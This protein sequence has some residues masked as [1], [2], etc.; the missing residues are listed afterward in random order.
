MQKIGKKWDSWIIAALI[1]IIESRG[2]ESENWARTAV[3]AIIEGAQWDLEVGR[4]LESVFSQWRE[5]STAPLTNAKA[6]EKW[7]PSCKLV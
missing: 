2:D 4:N 3:N 6:L 5:K 1:D 7:L